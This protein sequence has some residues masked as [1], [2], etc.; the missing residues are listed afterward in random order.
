MGT[1]VPP[2]LVEKI[3]PDVLILA[4]GGTHQIPDV[5]GIDNKIVNLKG[6][7]YPIEIFSK[8][9]QSIPVEQIV[10]SLVTECR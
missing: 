6:I 9:Y 1:E 5:P 4:T 10:Q 7:D 2:E 3:Q 8:V